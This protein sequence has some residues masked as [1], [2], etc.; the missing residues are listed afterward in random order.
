[1]LSRLLNLI[2]CFVYGTGSVLHKLRERWLVEQ[3]ERFE[4]G[5]EGGDLFRPVSACLDQAGLCQGSLIQFE[6]SCSSVPPSDPSDPRACGVHGSHT[7][8]QVHSSVSPGDEVHHV[9]W[10]KLFGTKKVAFTSNKVKDGLP[11]KIA[12]LLDFVQMRGGR[13]LPKIFVHFSQTVYT[14]SIWG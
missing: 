1:M 13:S 7:H 2:R 4:T 3:N 14:G 6:R 12:V 10:G 11:K 8:M 9:L 5:L